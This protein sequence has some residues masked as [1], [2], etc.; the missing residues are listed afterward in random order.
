MQGKCSS[1]RYTLCIYSVYNVFFL[2]DER[3]IVI[4]SWF[5]FRSCSSG[6]RV[7]VLFKKNIVSHTH[8][9]VPVSLRVNNS[10]TCVTIK[11]NMM[12]ILAKVLLS[13]TVDEIV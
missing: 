11:Q 13:R 5:C 12:M 6:V 7:L 8:S 2:C 9:L 10:Q 3:N 4:Y 1:G